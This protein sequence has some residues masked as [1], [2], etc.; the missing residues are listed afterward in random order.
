VSTL[1]STSAS[2]TFSVTLAPE[3]MTTDTK[4]ATNGVFNVFF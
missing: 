2:G 1:T 3:G 4:V